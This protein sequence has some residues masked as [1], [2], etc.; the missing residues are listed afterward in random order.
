MIVRKIY[1]LTALLLAASYAQ[2]QSEI[3]GVWKS[4]K[5]D[6]MIKIASMGPEFQGRIVWMRN[7]KDENGQQRLDIKNPEAKFRKLPIK[8]SRILK[9]LKFNSSSKTW[10]S[11]TLY[12]PDEGKIY[13]CTVTISANKLVINY[14]NG[15]KSTWSWTRQ[16]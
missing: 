1:F 11:G 10:E 2:A 7:E 15:G 4:D 14:S 8:G 13:Q 5:G 16:S 3:E 9:D 12:I 6:Y